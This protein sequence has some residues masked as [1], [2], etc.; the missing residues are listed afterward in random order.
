MRY[1]LIFHAIGGALSAAALMTAIPAMNW[2]GGAYVFLAWPLL[3]I[4]NLTGLWTAVPP[5]EISYYFFT[6]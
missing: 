1:Y 3:V 4:G 6:F 2:L 5:V